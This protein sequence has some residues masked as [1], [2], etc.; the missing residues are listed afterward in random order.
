M[1]PVIY[2]DNSATTQLLPEVKEAMVPFLFE[3]Y[4]NASSSHQVGREARNAIDNSRQQLAT[5]IG[6]HSSE[7][8]FSPSATYSNNTAILGRARYVEEQG[9]GRHII[10][11]KI[12]HSSSLLPAKHLEFRGWKLTLLDVDSEGFISIEQLKAAITADTS[13]I[14]IV[15]ANNEI[16]TIQ[17]VKEIGAIARELGIFFHVDA[18]Q[19]PGKIAIDVAEINADTLSLSAHKF[20]G[21]KGIGVL[22]VRKDVTLLPLTFGG[23]QERGLFPG[24]EGLANI[25]GIGKAAEIARTR[26]EANRKIL[27]LNQAVL[28]DKLLSYPNVKLTGPENLDNRLPGHVSI[29]V[30][31]VDGSELVLDADVRGLCVSSAS[32]CSAG[33]HEV[34][35][36]LTAIGAGHDA[37]GSLRITAG[38]LNTREEC[39]RAGDL[40]NSLISS[41]TYVPQ[42]PV[43][44]AHPIRLHSSEP[45]EFRSP[46]RA[47]SQAS[48]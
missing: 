34:S 29:L 19:V 31:G 25:V 48:L 36:V 46:S 11:T 33:K 40:L 8:Y 20:Y 12:E 10:T 7:I 32:A 18:V 9:L 13:I 4:G 15:W 39:E 27:K 14:S 1:R 24:T 37:I 17:P 45:I 43:V 23:G 2:L 28:L 3:E 30:P 21:P 5:L 16:G 42:A 35:H 22:Y 6:A 26:L 47:W 38:T 41:A 44:S